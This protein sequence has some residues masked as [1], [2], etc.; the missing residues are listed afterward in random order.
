[1]GI[2]VEA[3]C[4]EALERMRSLG[5]MASTIGQNRKMFSY[6]AEFAGH[7][8]YTEEIGKVSTYAS[9]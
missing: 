3:I 6:L 5:Y 1:M 4:D 7:G 8:D 9:S 2:T